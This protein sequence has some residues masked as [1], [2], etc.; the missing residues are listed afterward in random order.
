VPLDLAHLVGKDRHVAQPTLNTERLQL[1]PLAGDHLEFEV[2][3]DS[4]PEV[5]RYLSGRALSRAEVEQAHRRRIAAAREVPGLGFWVGFADGIFV[6]W[7]ILQPPHGPDEPKV[8]GQADLG[9]RL[10]R[11]QWRRGYA[12]EGARELI[13]YGF[14]EV[15]LDR[16][17]AQTMAVNTAS[18]ATMSAVGLTFVR[19]FVSG[20]RYDDPIPGAEQGEV[21]YE[22]TRTSWQR[23]QGVTG[24]VYPDAQN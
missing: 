7:W 8:A 1:V 3:L 21:E 18:R 13:R 4:D 6:G 11:R 15:G 23:R 19:A 12:S 17:F 24:R 22:I 2:G 5:M 9:Y 10:L 16:I 20:D 14:T